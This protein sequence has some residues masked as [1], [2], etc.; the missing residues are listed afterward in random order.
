MNINYNDILR[1]KFLKNN[2]TIPDLKITEIEIEFDDLLRLIC[3]VEEKRG[4]G[5]SLHK[6]AFS[7]IDYLGNE[8]KFNSYIIWTEDEIFKY[9]FSENYTPFNSEILRRK[10]NKNIDDVIGNDQ[11]C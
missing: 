1:V 10:R 9:N 6:E 8:V 11:K 2:E 5:R 3:E 4:I 7:G